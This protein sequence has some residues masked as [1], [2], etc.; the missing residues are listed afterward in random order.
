MSQ[1]AVN[2]P[3]QNTR[4]S[5]G[6]GERPRVLIADDETSIREVL[7]IYLEQE[8]FEVHTAIH[9]E[10]ACAKIAQLDLSLVLSDLRMPRGGGMKVLEYLQNQRRETLVIMMTALLALKRQWKQ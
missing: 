10:E 5:S 3:V 6:G 9:A 7:T 4:V 1:S 8:G 2:R